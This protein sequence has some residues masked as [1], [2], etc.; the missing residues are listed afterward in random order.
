MPVISLRQVFT[1]FYRD[2]CTDE[3]TCIYAIISQ[4]IGR[5][6]GLNYSQMLHRACALLKDVHLFQT[7]AN[8]LSL[9]AKAKDIV[10]GR[11]ELKVA[12]FCN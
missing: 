5:Y 12:I 1:V 7:N 3:R 2:Y 9:P 11:I 10:K 4:V 8:K 6:L